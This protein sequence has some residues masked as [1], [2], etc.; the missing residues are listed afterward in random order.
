MALRYLVED[1]TGIL[2]SATADDD[3]IAPPGHTAVLATTIE[4]AYDD[5]ILLYG[6]WDGTTY[7]PPAGYVAPFDPG[8]DQGAVKQAA[9][10]TLDVFD[11]AIGLALANPQAWPYTNISNAIIGIHWQIIA[12]ARVCLNSTRTA[13]RR[14]KFCEECASWPTG[15]SGD[16]RQ[17]VDGMGGIS[18]PP[19]EKWSWVDPEP[20]PYVRQS[21]A[22]AVSKFENA[23]NVE[24]APGSD[25]L[26]GRGWINDIPA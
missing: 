5:K 18:D 24:A 21:I 7:T 8:T 17:Y 15:L 19:G 1:S 14:Q 13:A 10:D 22:L 23:T 12:M 11:A 25:G 26:I 20:D 9:H 3:L 6:T 2:V 4:A 16:P